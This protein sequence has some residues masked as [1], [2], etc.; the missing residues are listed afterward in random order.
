MQARCRGASL[1]F[2][3]GTLWQDEE[4]IARGE[5]QKTGQR[6]GHISM[7]GEE[8]SMAALGDLDIA[9]RVFIHINN[10]NP[11]LLADSPER[12]AIEAAGWRVAYDGMEIT[13]P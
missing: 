9:R 3:D 7:S 11:A 1:L 2:F 5:G 4:M 10:T 8:G 13:L 12:Q 6:M